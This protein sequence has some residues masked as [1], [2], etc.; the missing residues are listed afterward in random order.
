M[1]LVTE[2][3]KSEIYRGPRD[4]IMVVATPTTGQELFPVGA[5]QPAGSLQKDV[6][7]CV[8]GPAHCAD[9]LAGSPFT[10]TRR[11]VVQDLAPSSEKVWTQAVA[12]L[13][14]LRGGAELPGSRAR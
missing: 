11:R 6:R 5:H 2:M 9:C 4:T 7:A 13:W 12:L 10:D 14:T 8:P 1:A 3:S